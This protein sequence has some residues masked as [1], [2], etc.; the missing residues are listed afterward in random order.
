M[1]DP[2]EIARVS[3]IHRQLDDYA[4]APRFADSRERGHVFLIATPYE[5]YRYTAAEIISWPE[6]KA[7][8]TL[9]LKRFESDPGAAFATC[10]GMTGVWRLIGV[11][12]TVLQPA[13]DR[14]FCMYRE[15]LDATPVEAL[16]RCEACEEPSIG[17]FTLVSEV[18]D[19]CGACSDRSATAVATEIGLKRAGGAPASAEKPRCASCSAPFTPAPVTECKDPSRCVY[20]QF[21]ELAAFTDTRAA[22]SRALPDRTPKRPPSRHDARPLDLEQAWST[23]GWES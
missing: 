8:I 20:C 7:E 22:L 2:K 23:P 15:M 1:T 18:V 13:I 16:K 6:T 19:L 12:P 10:D 5:R 4:T 3:D 14:G 11:R 9:C 17:S 21:R